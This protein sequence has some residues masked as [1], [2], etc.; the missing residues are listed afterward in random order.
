MIDGIEIQQDSEKNELKVRSRDN[1]ET[2]IFKQD[3]SPVT[4]QDSRIYFSITPLSS[5]QKMVSP[6]CMEYEGLTERVVFQNS[7][8]LAFYER[9]VY[10]SYVPSPSLPN[11]CQNFLEQLKTKIEDH[12]APAFWL[13]AEQTHGIDLNHFQNLRKADI[14]FIFR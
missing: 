6:G 9:T 10:V 3:H 11:S 13:A 4:N 8:R 7:Q 1:P 14:H 12:Q 2:R 5:Q